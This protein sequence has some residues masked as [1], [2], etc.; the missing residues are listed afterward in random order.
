MIIYV[1]LFELNSFQYFKMRIDFFILVLIILRNYCI[2]VMLFN[3][4]M[5]VVMK[6]L[7]ILSSL[8]ILLLISCDETSNPTSEGNLYVEFENLSS[9]YY[10]IF[11]IELQPM[12]KAGESDPTPKGDWGSNILKN[13]NLII[14][15]QKVNFNLNIPGGDWSNAR[16][17]VIDSSGQKVYLH[18]Q[19]NYTP[20]FNC[21]ITNWGSNKREVAVNIMFDRTRGLI[22]INSWSDWAF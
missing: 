21:P 5:K 2:F 10:S 1:L 13:G 19:T 20:D 15:G 12:G 22:V 11:S 8:I 7:F 18:Q 14:P 17:G 16:L 3:K 4:L 6:Y 9:S